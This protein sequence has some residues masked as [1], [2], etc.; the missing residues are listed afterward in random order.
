MQDHYLLKGPALTCAYPC[1][2][3]EAVS[4]KAVDSYDHARDGN[5]FEEQ[6]SEAPVTCDKL[7]SGIH[8]VADD[9]RNCAVGAGRLPENPYTS[10]TEHN[11]WGDFEGFTE[12]LANSE[13]LNSALGV[14]AIKNLQNVARFSETHCTTSNGPNVPEPAEHEKNIAATVSR[15]EVCLS[16]E[17]IFISSF[18][19]VPV[20]KSSENI[21]SL[22]R[23]LET[24]N[25]EKGVIELM[26]EQ[27]RIGSV[28]I[29][30]T[31]HGA[32]TE[33]G[34][35]SLWNE[36]HCLKSLML[37]LGIDFD[38]KNILDG[39]DSLGE[40]D[41]KNTEELTEADGSAINGSQTLIQTKLSVSPDMKRGRFFTYQ[42]FIKK[43]P[44]DRNTPSIMFP[45]KKNIFA[46][47]NLEMK[48]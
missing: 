17:D 35:Q 44:S 48:T 22:S 24:S 30:R 12:S 8:D 19:D 23:L 3:T 46:A 25:E 31:T 29:W 45:G 4:D 5:N 43:M 36:S 13:S 33:S 40:T 20:Q 15:A 32:T 14:Q 37:T 7:P 9:V 27:F 26:K 1:A 39:V 6:H 47:H 41:L 16:Y 11:S 18:P 2:Y 28:N 38:R 34:L 42:L 21:V 10:E